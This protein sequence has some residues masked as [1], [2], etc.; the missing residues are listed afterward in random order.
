MYINIHVINVYKRYTCTYIIKYV[1]E[2]SIVSLY[3]YNISGKK[4]IKHP[5]SYLV[6][7]MYIHQKTFLTSIMSLNQYNTSGGKLKHPFSHS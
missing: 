7:C 1:F 5:Y 6:G 2:T 3:K 4:K